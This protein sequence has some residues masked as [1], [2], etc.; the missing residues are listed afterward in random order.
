M[1]KP[2]GSED[3]PAG[4]GVL[5][6]LLLC[7]V[8]RPCLRRGFILV[9]LSAVGLFVS[10]TYSKGLVAWS[11]IFVVNPMI[12]KLFTGERIWRLGL[13]NNPPAILHGFSGI[14]YASQIGSQ[15]K[16][17]SPDSYLDSVT[18]QTLRDFGRTNDEVI[19]TQAGTSEIQEVLPEDIVVKPRIEVEE[20]GASASDQTHSTPGDSEPTAESSS[21][22]MSSDSS[23]SESSSTETA[24]S[25]P[26]EIT[27][28]KIR[29]A[30]QTQSTS[31]CPPSLEQT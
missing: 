9:L 5:T 24:P 10:V 31:K 23:H 1:W 14:G 16:N 15:E 2:E 12:P 20:R 8:F 28:T 11:S 27:G 17:D 26:D 19:G 13:G 22:G 30:H 7:Q 3:S 18:S 29:P 6:T 21:T 4:N 25:G